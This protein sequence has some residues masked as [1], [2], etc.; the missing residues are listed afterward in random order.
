M[1]QR[2]LR[3]FAFGEMATMTSDPCVATTWCVADGRP[4]WNR[5]PVK[6]SDLLT[7]APA[8][9]PRDLF[10]DTASKPVNTFATRWSFEPRSAATWL[11]TCT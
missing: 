8:H 3:L 1:F 5:R 10:Y 2:D 4:L 6:R 7:S 11:S 9:T